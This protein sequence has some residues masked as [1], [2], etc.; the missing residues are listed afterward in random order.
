MGKKLKV[1]TTHATSMA[2]KC[3]VFITNPIAGGVI[4]KKGILADGKNTEGSVVRAKNATTNKKNG[5]LANLIM[6]ALK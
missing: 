4:K 1:N 3:E 2:N 6:D 5:Y